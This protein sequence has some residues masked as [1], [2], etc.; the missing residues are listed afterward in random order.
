MF[1]SH[2]W[3]QSWL[4]C[5]PLFTPRLS[6]FGLI[7]A[8]HNISTLPISYYKYNEWL[9]KVEIG[10]HSPQPSPYPGFWVAGGDNYGRNPPTF[11]TKI[12]CFGLIQESLCILTLPMSQ[13]KYNEWL[14]EVENVVWALKWSPQACFSHDWAWPVITFSNWVWLSFYYFKPFTTSQPFQPLTSSIMNDLTMLRLEFILN[15]HRH[16]PAFE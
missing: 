7:G 3:G 11:H 6:E 1:F 13:Y 2:R 16:T 15:N 8:I 9:E 14:E 4:T 10:T 5:F 12:V